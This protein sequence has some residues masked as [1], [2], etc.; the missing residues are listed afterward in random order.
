MEEESK[1]LDAVGGR[2]YSIEVGRGDETVEQWPGL[3]GDVWWDGPVLGDCDMR[4]LSMMAGQP[5]LFAACQWMKKVKRC[6]DAVS[7]R[8]SIA[9]RQT[10]ESVLGQRLGVW[11]D[12]ETAGSRSAGGCFIVQSVRRTRRTRV[13][14]RHVKSPGRAV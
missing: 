4:G 12:E 5:W 10:P 13:T 7:S 1:R 8:P 14:M 6:D 3:S 9:E 2:D 11:S